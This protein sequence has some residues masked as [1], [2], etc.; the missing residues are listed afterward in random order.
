MLS[1]GHHVNYSY[2]Q[3]IRHLEAEI[4]SLQDEKLGR[5]I[6]FTDI[7]YE[8]LRQ[9][10]DALEQHWK[11]LE[12]EIETMKEMRSIS[13]KLSHNTKQFQK[14]TKIDLEKFI[15]NSVD[16]V[17]MLKYKEVADKLIKEKL[18]NERMRDEIITLNK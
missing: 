2:N 1:I 17:S 9:N 6:I 7:D 10:F 8:L 11:D 4:Q 5:V 14:H 12:S 3:E 15:P 16:F 13:S 18:K